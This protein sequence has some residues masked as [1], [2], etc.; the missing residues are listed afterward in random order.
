[1][2][3]VETV[4]ECRCETS[5]YRQQ[6][7][8]ALTEL[9][10]DEEGSKILATKVRFLDTASCNGKNLPNFDPPPSAVAGNGDTQ[11]RVSKNMRAFSEPFSP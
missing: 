5:C 11:C 3:S 10:E 4:A 9:K 7:N 1:M 8:V 6:F 2:M